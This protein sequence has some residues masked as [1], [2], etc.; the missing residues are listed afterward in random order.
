MANTL[1]DEG[2][3]FI[4]RNGSFD[5]RHPLEVQSGDVDCTDMDDAEFEMFV[6]AQEM[7]A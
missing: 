7:V 6:M 3:R 4:C 2:F 1:K 5:W